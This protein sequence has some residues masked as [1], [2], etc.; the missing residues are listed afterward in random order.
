MKVE[1]EWSSPTT[2]GPTAGYQNFSRSRAAR[3]A[4]RRTSISQLLRTPGIFLYRVT[5]PIGAVADTLET[6]RA[7]G[8]DALSTSVG[9]HCPRLSR[10]LA[11]LS[12]GGS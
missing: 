8:Q 11:A 7:E 2:R 9:G 6:R 1:T 10:V 5:F 4:R 3:R 12:A